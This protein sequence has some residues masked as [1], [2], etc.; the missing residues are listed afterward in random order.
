MVEEDWCM[1]I[2]RQPASQG[3]STHT[4]YGQCPDSTLVMVPTAASNDTRQN[5]CE[6]ASEGTYA[7]QAEE[8]SCT[9]CCI[10]LGSCVSQEGEEHVNAGCYGTPPWSVGAVLSVAF[11]R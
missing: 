1:P 2:Q 6:D 10:G 11:H 4:Q 9:Q 5:V 3:R 7:Q 8:Y